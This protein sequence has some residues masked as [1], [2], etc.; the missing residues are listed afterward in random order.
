MMYTLENRQIRVECTK[1]LSSSVE[2]RHVTYKTKKTQ[3]RKTVECKK[4]PS[5]NGE[6]RDLECKKDLSANGKL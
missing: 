1:D 5:A 6:I 3:L 4:D 2:I